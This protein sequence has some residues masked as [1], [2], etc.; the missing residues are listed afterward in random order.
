[1]VFLIKFFLGVLVKWLKGYEFNIEMFFII[2]GFIFVLYGCWEEENV[3]KFWLIESLECI[4]LFK[5]DCMVS[6]IFMFLG[7]IIIY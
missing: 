6:I 7:L 3:I 4:V 1:M 5:L 2:D